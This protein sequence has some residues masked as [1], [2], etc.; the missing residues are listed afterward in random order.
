M[1]GI[2]KAMRHRPTK[3]HSIQRDRPRRHPK[4]KSQKTEGVRSTHP[5]GLP[6]GEK[7]MQVSRPQRMNQ[8]MRHPGETKGKKEKEK[9]K[10]KQET[11]ASHLP[12]HF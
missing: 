10:K 7:D 3:R 2:G 6:F 4:A 11:G 1:T 12:V 5:K 9:K 8:S